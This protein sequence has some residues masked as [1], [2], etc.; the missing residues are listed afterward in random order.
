LAGAF[1]PQSKR[2]ESTEKTQCPY[3]GSIV[4]G[5]EMAEQADAA[6][7]EAAERETAAALAMLRRGAPDGLEPLIPLVYAELRRV[8]HRQLAVEPDG[9]TLSTTALVHEAYLRLADQT[10]VEWTSRAQFFGLAARAMRRVLVDYARRH[11]AARRGG[12]QQRPVALDDAEAD[13]DALTVAA[14]GDELI[15]LDEALERLSTLDARLARV[16][17]CRFFGGLTEVET[18][19]ALGVSQRTVASDWLMAKGWLYQALLPE[20]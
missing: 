11:Q 13:A 12:P 4:R 6:A 3:A 15:A 2:A 7:H 5:A 20:S 17:E 9:H 1:W 16:V 8:A 14:R 10:R 18:A 19:E